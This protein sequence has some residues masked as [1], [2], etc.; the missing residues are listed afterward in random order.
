MATTNT[1]NKNSVKNRFKNLEFINLYSIVF[2]ARKGLKTKIFYDF[3]ETIKMPEKNLASIMR[4]FKS[5]VTTNARK[6][7]D[8]LFNWQ[9]R[10]HDHIIRNADE[11]ERIAAYIENNPTQWQEDK[12][13]LE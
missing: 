3:A 11:Y 2:L 13:F 9:T 1:Q 10:Y 7:D 6:M 5:S 4:G 12:F 8:A